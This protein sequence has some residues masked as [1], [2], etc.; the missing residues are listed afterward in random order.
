MLGIFQFFFN[1]K[2]KSPTTTDYEEQILA[3]V[4]LT[5]DKNVWT[6]DVHFSTEKDKNKENGS[7][8]TFI[9]TI[10]AGRG[11]PETVVLIHGYGATGVFFFKM[12]A[13]M[14]KY[15]H[16]YAIDQL[17][18]GSSDRPCY[19]TKDYDETV[20]FFAEAIEAWR[21][22]LGIEDFHL[23]GHSFGGYT[24]FQYYRT[25]NPPIKSLYLLSPAGFTSKSDEEIEEIYQKMIKGLVWRQMMFWSVFYLMEEWQFTP[26]Q[27]MTVMGRKKT[28]GKYY[29]S[30]RLGLN[31]QQAELFA[32]YYYEVMRLPTSS[33][34]ALGVFLNKGR[35]SRRPIVDD[36]EEI[37]KKGKLPGRFVVMYGDDDWMDDEHSK[38]EI[39]RRGLGVDYR[40]V[41]DCGHQ[42]TLKEPVQ[43]A[44]MFVEALGMEFKEVAWG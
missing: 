2:T 3:T 43:I 17:G 38:E 19:N 34:K 16:V 42:M 44:K 35:Y 31:D 30:K 1:P 8:K 22:E 7:K 20:S 27:L 6:Y 11:H 14:S 23:M 24:A 26:F 29:K 21:K 37:S 4:G 36:L 13:Q 25:K 40:I 18:T 32:N 41:K 15:A 9:H 12:M 5:K 28:M 39:D 10:E 33:D